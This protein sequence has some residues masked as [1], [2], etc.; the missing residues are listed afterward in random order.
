VGSYHS[1]SPLKVAGTYNTGNFPNIAEPMDYGHQKNR[2]YWREKYHQ[3][4]DHER[5]R[6][7]SSD[8]ANGGGDK[9]KKCDVKYFHKSLSVFRKQTSLHS[10]VCRDVFTLYFL[11]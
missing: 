10:Q 4:W 8:R 2:L 7:E 5:G 9:G 1:L 11:K 3:D 6:P